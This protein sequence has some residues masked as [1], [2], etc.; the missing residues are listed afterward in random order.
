ML[1]RRGEEKGGR[2]YE[3][4]LVHAVSLK[5]KWEPPLEKDRRRG[6]LESG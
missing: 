2:G 1:W 3:E 5:Q 6:R 4:G